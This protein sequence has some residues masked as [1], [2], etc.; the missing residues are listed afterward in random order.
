MIHIWLALGLRL[1]SLWL[2]VASVHCVFHSRP[3]EVVPCIPPEVEAP[4]Q[5]LV[6]SAIPEEAE[7]ELEKD[8][9]VPKKT[10]THSI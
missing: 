8:G 5:P 3:A 1:R 7:P 10:K 9:D 6:S 4:S 2:V